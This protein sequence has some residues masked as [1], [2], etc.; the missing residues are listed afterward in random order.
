MILKIVKKIKNRKF[1]TNVFI[2][3]FISYYSFYLSLEKCTEGEDRCCLKLSWMKL[4]IIEE[5]ISCIIIIILLE[6]IILRKI[7][8]LHIVHI[9][10]VFTLF[11]FYS[12]G[13]DFDDHGYYNIQY[14]FIINISFL[15]LLFLLNHLLSLKNK[16][17]ILIVFESLLI[18]LYYIR[19]LIYNSFG[20][21]DWKLGLNNTSID[22]NVGKYGCKIKIPKYCFYKIG[23][24]FL[25]KNKFSSLDCNEF[26]KNSRNKI[27]KASNSSFINQNTLHIGFPLVNKDKN[28][29]NNIDYYT[30]R[31]Y[32][33][34]NYIDMNNLTL[35]N[36]LG[37]KKP[38]IS[39][40]FSK[41]KIGQMKINLNYNKTLSKIRKKLEG[42]TN[43]LSKNI[44]VI[45]IDSVSRAYS[46][47]QLKKTLKFFEKF[48]SY[49]GNS[50]DKFPFENFHSF[51]FFKYHSHKYYTI[52]NY[53]PLFYGNHRKETNKYITLYLKRNGFLTSYSSDNCY[54][55]FVR[56]FH[57]FTSSDIYDHHYVICD[58]NYVLPSP[59]L[60][61]F[62]GKI[63]VEFLIEYINQFWRKYK[64]NRKFSLLLTNFAHEGSLEKLKY[65]DNI[66]YEF[67]N[68]LYNDNLLKE[69]SILLL[70]DHG[71]AIPS[72]YYL[73]DFFK[74]EKVLPMFYLLVN[75]RKNISYESQY[76]Y[77]YKNQQ[78]F[79][80]AFDIYN[81]L[82][83]I[84]YGDKYGT[85]E[86]NESISKYGKSL[87]S[88]INQKRRIPKNYRSMELY[89]CI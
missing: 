5:A 86:T 63:Y 44:L 70:S 81:T 77:L 65:I 24:Y 35:I 58:P 47:R 18:F 9:I 39:V 36:L 49:K 42:K 31:K 76:K 54:N 41:N 59:N 11:Y 75:D 27:L 40:D 1:N 32:I 23:K 88:K 56:C 74:Y 30:F 38:E 68:N 2:L 52:G 16:K 20:C 12:H 19:N 14:F 82:I 51:Q 10:I 80:T 57:N 37:D 21:E 25:D 64:D 4:K 3:F 84:I 78:T 15:I 22:N 48:I 61:C 85:V 17:I 53:P 7:S 67:L 46:I 6:L 71:V 66:I 34:E 50:N 79:I 43:P 29:F 60:N 26:G 83:N 8:K 55:D 73:T 33:R 28:L 13:I 89:A 87:F 72:I 45:F 69:T 62:Y